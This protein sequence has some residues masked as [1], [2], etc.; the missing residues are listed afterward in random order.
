MLAREH[1]LIAIP[2]SWRYRMRQ[3]CKQLCRARAKCNFVCGGIK[4]YSGRFGA[5]GDAG[6][7][8]QPNG[9]GRAELDIGVQEVV[10]RSVRDGFECLWAMSGDPDRKRSS[11]VPESLRRCLRICSQT[12]GRGTWSGQVEHRETSFKMALAASAS[13]QDGAHSVPK[14]LN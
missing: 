9:I 10:V 12:R 3:I 6:H 5:T 1:N 13:N 14:R 8:A 4:Q 7:C 11:G 2:K